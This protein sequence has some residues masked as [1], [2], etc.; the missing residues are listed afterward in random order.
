MGLTGSNE[1]CRLQV[2]AAQH[3]WH[4]LGEKREGEGGGT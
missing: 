2:Q 4:M 1:L 3:A